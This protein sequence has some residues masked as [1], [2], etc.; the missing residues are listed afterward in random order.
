[1]DED[2]P[3]NEHCKKA[4]DTFQDALKRWIECKIRASSANLSVARKIGQI[5][6]ER[7]R[8]LTE[9]LKKAFNEMI[10]AC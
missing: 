2:Y 9:D 4:Y 1:M 3:M 8:A 10:K 5:T 7:K 6:R